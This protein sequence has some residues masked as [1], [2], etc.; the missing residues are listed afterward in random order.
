MNKSRR[1]DLCSVFC[2]NLG[3]EE[4]GCV[5]EADARNFVISSIREAT[6]EKK[7]EK[8]VVRALGD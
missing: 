1:T 8:K 7:T 4:G 5:D 3:S 6:E 2:N